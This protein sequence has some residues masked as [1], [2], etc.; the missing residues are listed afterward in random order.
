MLLSRISS[1]LIFKIRNRLVLL[2]TKSLNLSDQFLTVRLMCI[3]F[4]ELTTYNIMSW[5]NLFV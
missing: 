3:I 2:K 5:A 1:L 4:M